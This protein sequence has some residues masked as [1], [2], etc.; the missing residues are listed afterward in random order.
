MYIPSNPKK[1]K[2]KERPG[3]CPEC[4]LPGWWNGERRVKQKVKQVVKGAVGVVILV[5]EIV[6]RRARCPNEDCPMGSWTEY[7]EGGYPYRRFSL[8]VVALA[9]AQIFYALSRG[10][11]A[12][13]TFLDAAELHQCGLSSLWR[14]VKWVA[15]LFVARDLERLCMR[16]DPEGLPPPPVKPATTWVERAGVVL[17]LL[18]RLVQLLRFRGVKLEP[19][20]GLKA[21]L[22][23]QLVRFRKFLLLTKSS[24]Q[25]KLREEV[26]M[27]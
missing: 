13:D 4:G 8:D 2:H 7:E 20:S 16:L 27:A 19:G 26:A 12:T 15:G 6:R 17:L 23:H 18:E 1:C 5:V 14:W 21:I 24:P 3:P 11:N 9:V 22:W 10:E 25:M